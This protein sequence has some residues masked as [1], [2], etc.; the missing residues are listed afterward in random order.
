MFQNKTD[1]ADSLFRS[2]DDLWASVKDGRYE[3]QK[4]RMKSCGLVHLYYLIEDYTR[5]LW[6]GGGRGGGA[7][8]EAINQ[9]FIVLSR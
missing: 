1:L 4:F 6:A 5:D 7:T 2:L 9:V 8:P 3:E